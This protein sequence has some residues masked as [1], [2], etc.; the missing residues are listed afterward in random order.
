M[1]SNNPKL[2]DLLNNS[3]AYSDDNV[4]TAQSTSTADLNVYVTNDGDGIVYGLVDTN[5][6]GNLDD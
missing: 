4:L 1:S 2:I 3:Y 6:T 5:V